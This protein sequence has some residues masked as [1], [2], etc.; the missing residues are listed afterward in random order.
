MVLSS[1]MVT[2]NYIWRSYDGGIGGIKFR[3]SHLVGMCFTTWLRKNAINCNSNWLAYKF[4]CKV[5]WFYIL[6]GEQT[7]IKEIVPEY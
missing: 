4:H 1:Q 6:T 2:F 5:I 7:E 3:T